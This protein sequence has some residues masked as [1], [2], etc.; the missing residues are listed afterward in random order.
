MANIP[1]IETARLKLIPLDVENAK[2]DN[3]EEVVQQL[4]M[5][6]ANLILGE[7]TDQKIKTS[8]RQSLEALIKDKKKGQWYDDWESVLIILK[9][10]NAL[11]G[12]FCFQKNPEEYSACHI[13]YMIKPEY[14]NNGY[15]T[16]ALREGI[17]WIF[18]NPDI[19]YLLAET[20]KSN[21]ASQQV[22]KKI[23]MT[24]YRETAQ[25]LMWEIE[26]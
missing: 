14:Q 25:S 17:T 13:G 6:L 20:S 2:P 11:I 19:S 24:V 9:N 5:Q 18:Q 3:H 22:L 12:G 4:G 23:G 8:M 1:V 10:T 7:K 15:M 26:Y 16:E 21:L